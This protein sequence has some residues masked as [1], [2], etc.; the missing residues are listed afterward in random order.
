MDSSDIASLSLLIILILMSAFFSSAE[1]A[2]MTVNSIKIRN[3]SSDG[4]KSALIAQKV[5]DEKDKMLSAI[6]IGNNIVNLSASSL[7]TTLSLKLF[8][9]YA[10]SFVTGLLTLFILVFGEISPKTI[11]SRYS[12]N[13]AMSYSRIIFFL[14]I[15]LTPLIFVVNLAAGIVMKLFGADAKGNKEHI[16]EEELRTIVDVGHEEGIIEN[17]ERKMINNVFDFGDT[18]V[19]ELMIPRIDMVSIDINATFDELMDLYRKEQYT[20]IPV[21]KD[22]TD[23]VIG[24]INAKDLLLNDNKENFNI[25]RILREPL[26]T[27]EHKNVSELLL[28]MKKNFHNIVIVLDEYGM[29]AGLLTLED[30]LEEIFGEIRDEYDRDEEENIKKINE[31]EYIVD[32][33]MKI[34]DINEYFNLSLS[35]QD[36]ESIGGLTLEK[37]GHLPKEGEEC[38]INELQ[39]K[40]EKMDKNRIEKLRLYL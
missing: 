33:S 4:K 14:M 17:E 26:F 28:E 11:A 29:A 16:T 3:L 5:L 13:L 6:L 36:Y 8:G 2:F 31:K 35:S 1:T 27:Y 38:S 15:I 39:L 9:S 22:S 30:I 12:E 7:A 32:A 34:D 25:K 40:V 21:Y 23:N 24:I 10:V 19:R 18:I 20:R 37:L